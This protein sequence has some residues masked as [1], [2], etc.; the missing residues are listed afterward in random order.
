MFC[1]LYLKWTIIAAVFPYLR[2]VCFRLKISYSRWPFYILD[3]YSSWFTFLVVK[4]W[5][6]TADTRRLVTSNWICVNKWTLAFRVCANAFSIFFVLNLKWITDLLSVYSL[7]FCALHG[8][9]WQNAVWGDVKGVAV[10]CCVTVLEE[11]IKT[12]ENSPQSVSELIFWTWSSR[13]NFSALIFHVHRLVRF[14]W[15]CF[16][17]SGRMQ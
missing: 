1:L 12:Q 2:G 8:V 3:T 13:G 17:C 7:C 11:P 14:N 4:T 10:A 5:T 6:W 9:E 16:N 15:R